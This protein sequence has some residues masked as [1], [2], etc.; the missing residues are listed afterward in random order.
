MAI[1]GKKNTSWDREPDD[2][3]RRIESS[4]VK[5]HWFNRPFIVQDG[6]AALVFSK[7]RMQG[8]V[9]A[10]QH[11]VDGLL[12]RYI[13]GDAP[14][15]FVLV[16]DG[17]IPFD[18]DV[19]GLYS[20]DHVS[21][22]AKLRVVIE[23]DSAEAFY[24]NVM[25]DRR[26]FKIG[27]MHERIRPEL[28]DAIGSFVA[29]LPIDAVF[30]SSK[31]DAEDGLRQHLGPHLAAVGFRIAALSVLGYSSEDYGAHLD[32]S[33]EVEMSSKDA[34]LEGMR[35]VVN[36]RLRETLAADLEHKAST[37]GDL[38]NAL[39]QVLHD[40]QVKD[41]LRTDEMDRLHLRLEQDLEDL[42]RTRTRARERIE[43]GHEQDLQRDRSSFERTES[44]KDLDHVIDADAAARDHGR[45]QDGLD[46]DANLE[47][48]RKTSETDEVVRDAERRGDEKDLDL[49]KRKRD[50]K[51]SE[52]ERLKKIEAEDFQRRAETLKDA[53]TSTKIALG[54]GD[55]AS[56]LELERLEKQQGLSEDQM[57]ILAAEKSPAVAAAL[58]ERFRAEGRS[59][60]D[61][62][63]NLQRQLEMQQSMSRDHAAQLERVMHQALGQMGQVASS[64]A[65]AGGPGNQTI[66]TGGQG[67]P[68]VVNPPSPEP[69]KDEE[70]KEASDS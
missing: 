28:R 20:G 3:A 61:M 69:P 67:T 65:A 57:L 64:R 34:D 30:K 11:D 32:R 4:D 60:E 40:L 35:S 41:R 5:R 56:L 42:A 29:G 70:G 23:L 19:D 54:A 52:M 62:M 10:G 39:N 38:R 43:Q 1:F 17:Q 16:D 37:K 6:V 2:L 25:R 53:D 15:T 31:G 33:A 66:V 51:L 50:D 44:R 8:R 45:G 26:R 13:V 36:R 21:L 9:E 58:A 22:G 7:G 59:S 27:E 24:R 49:K 55:A 48:R 46:L 18:F 47:G 63:E 14:T 68:T 12:R